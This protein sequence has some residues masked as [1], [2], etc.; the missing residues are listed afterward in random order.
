MRERTSSEFV[1]F[2]EALRMNFFLSLKIF[3]IGFP[4]FISKKSRDIL[5]LENVYSEPK[6]VAWFL[7]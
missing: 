7:K 6:F 5:V 4:I 1:S 3:K 2:S